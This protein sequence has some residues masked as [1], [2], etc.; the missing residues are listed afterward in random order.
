[1]ALSFLRNKPE[2]TGNILK[3]YLQSRITF[4]GQHGNSCRG[5][6]RARY[7][8]LSNKLKEFLSTAKFRSSKAFFRRALHYMKNQIC[9][10]GFNLS[11]IFPPVP[12]SVKFHLLVPWMK[13]WVLSFSPKRFVRPLAFYTQNSPKS[14]SV[15][16]QSVFLLYAKKKKKNVSSRF[17][18]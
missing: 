15:K 8:C 18:K 16:F 9:T 5:R 2:G 7:I 3:F 14:P 13:N 10:L 6:Q 1:M 12:F 4:A 11:Q 17:T